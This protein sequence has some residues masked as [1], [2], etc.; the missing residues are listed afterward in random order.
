MIDPIT[1]YMIRESFLISDKTISIDFSKFESGGRLFIVGMSG[2][3]KTTVG[4]SLQKKYKSNICH[5]DGCWNQFKSSSTAIPK[6]RK[7]ENEDDMIDQGY[8]CMEEIIKDKK[9][10][11]IVEGINLVGPPFD[12]YWS[13]IMKEAC[14]IMGKSA[15]KAAFDA[16]MRDRK[17]NR[18]FFETLKRQFKNN[19]DMIE[20]LDRF[21]RKRISLG[22][23]IKEFSM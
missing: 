5:L 23:D 3:G 17:M 11:R 6:P 14:I 1:E 10:C 18:P 20:K 9:G 21:R 8:D 22:G 15:V 2:S 4:R 13:L 16:A 12:K 19:K 7:G